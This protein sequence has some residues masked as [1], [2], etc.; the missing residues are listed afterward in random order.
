[1]I[2]ILDHH[3]II[4]KYD[5]SSVITEEDNRTAV[6]YIEDLVAKGNYF[7]NSPRY[8]TNVNLFSTNDA[9]WLKYKQS[10]LFS[11]NM[12][13]NKEC[14]F[15]DL[16]SWSYMT[17]IDTEEDRDSYWHHHNNNPWR[18][19]MSGIFYLHIPTDVE[20][21]GYCGTEFSLTDNTNK[22]TFFVSPKEFSWSIFP[23]N[24]MHRSGIA[25]SRNFRFIIAAD[26]EYV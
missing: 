16:M 8:Q 2:P 24:L 25:Q 21:L 22:D 26:V 9:T 4:K 5:F 18:K 13:L 6:K 17:N 7:T 23:S 3:D 12:Y 19:K 15:S 14:E 20:N 1:M 10:F 11:V